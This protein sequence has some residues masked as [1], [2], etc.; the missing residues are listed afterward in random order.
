MGGLDFRN[1]EAFNLSML[2]K[3]SWKLLSNS[4]LYLHEFSKPNISR[5]GISWM[6][7]SIGHNPS[8]TWRSLWSTQ[9]LLTLDHRWK[10][11]DG[12]RI[13]VWNTPWL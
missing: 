11:S 9:H 5:E 7:L 8:Y 10:I 6:P 3:Q 2:G 12:S 1:M 13:K 4:F